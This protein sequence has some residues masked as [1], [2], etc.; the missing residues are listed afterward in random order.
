V[1]RKARLVTEQRAGRER[2][3]ELEPAALK[4]IAAWIEGYRAFWQISLA[5]LKRRL[6]NEK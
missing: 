4:P 2:L 6:E 5:N 3:Y 1:L